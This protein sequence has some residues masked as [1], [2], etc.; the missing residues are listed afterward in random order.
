MVQVVKE[1]LKIQ[2]KYFISMES[3]NLWTVV[4]NAMKQNHYAEK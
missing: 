3:G 4:P 1:W 2:H